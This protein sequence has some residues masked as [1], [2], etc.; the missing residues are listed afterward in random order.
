MESVDI[1][2]LA[3]IVLFKVPLITRQIKTTIIMM[4]LVDNDNSI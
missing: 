4:A 3:C 2:S 1:A